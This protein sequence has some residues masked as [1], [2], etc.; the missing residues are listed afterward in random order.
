MHVNFQHKHTFEKNRAAAVVHGN[1]N[2]FK[3]T[4]T[5]K[6]VTLLFRSVFQLI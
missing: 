1:Y 2:S 6:D 4:M 5:N 3:A